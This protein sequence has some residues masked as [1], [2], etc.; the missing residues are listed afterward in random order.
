MKHYK[1]VF[2]PEHKDAGTQG[3]VYEHRLLAEKVVGRQLTKNEI[4]HHKDGNKQNNSLDNLEVLSKY[5][6]QRVHAQERAL[7]ISGDANKMRCAYCKEYD[8]P[9]NMY[10][11]KTIYQAWHRECANEYKAVKSPKTGPYKYKPRNFKLGIKH[12]G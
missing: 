11:R 1:K 9:S 6:H 3:H 5:E 12:D 2:V 10:V 8:L 4:V 7:K